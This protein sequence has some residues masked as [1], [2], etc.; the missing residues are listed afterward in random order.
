MAGLIAALENGLTA[1]ELDSAVASD[2]A[3]G[4]SGRARRAVEALEDSEAT[5]LARSGE[6]VAGGLVPS[7]FGSHIRRRAADSNKEHLSFADRGEDA[8]GCNVGSLPV[9]GYRCHWP[10]GH[11]L[12]ST[13]GRVQNDDGVVTRPPP[14][15]LKVIDFKGG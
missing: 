12:N 10:I 4:A 7:E 5:A 9:P 2:L 15:F 8:V 3:V 6:S 14:C 11:V 13:L 1:M